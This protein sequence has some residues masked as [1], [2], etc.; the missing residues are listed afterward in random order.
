MI[1]SLQKLNVIGKGSQIDTKFYHLFYSL[2]V[3]SIFTFGTTLKTLE[4]S[5]V[6]VSKV[7]Q[8]Q[9]K[10]LRVLNLQRC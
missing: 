10:N 9:I 2:D 5:D 1:S 3:E 4:I 8:V 6:W 7:L